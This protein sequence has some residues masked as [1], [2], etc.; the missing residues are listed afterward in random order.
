MKCPNCNHKTTPDKK[1][2]ERCGTMINQN[3]NI[4]T[5]ETN[6][7]KSFITKHKIKIILGLVIVC[8]VSAVIYFNS[9]TYLEKKLSKQTWYRVPKYDQ[10]ECYGMIGNASSYR[11]Y[12]NGE[13]KYNSYEKIGNSE[14]H[15]DYS[16]RDDW[17]ILDDKTLCIDGVYYEWKTEWYLSGNTL[18]FGEN[19]DYIYKTEDKWGYPD[20]Y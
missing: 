8:I 10:N 19:N 16:E 14:W 5:S 1:Y 3:I 6:Q 11:F 15:E 18:K 13:Y 7:I 9:V 12:S 4:N 20:S 2:C 17:E